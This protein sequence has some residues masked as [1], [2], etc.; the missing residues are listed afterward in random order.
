MSNQ[1]GLDALSMSYDEDVRALRFIET[2]DFI[3]TIE[4]GVITGVTGIGFTVAP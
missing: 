1:F 2:T 3:M 4:S